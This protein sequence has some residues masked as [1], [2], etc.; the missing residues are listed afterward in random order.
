MD[1][2][3]SMTGADDVVDVRVPIVR[4]AGALDPKN[5][6]FASTAGAV[7]TTAAREETGVCPLDASAVGLGGGGIADLGMR[8]VGAD[9]N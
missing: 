2:P 3:V 9:A 8:T 1:S 5:D 7:G 4:N 6:A